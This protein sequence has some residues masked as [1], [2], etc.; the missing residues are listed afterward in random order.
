M[1]PKELRFEVEFLTPHAVAQQAAIPGSALKG[2]MLDAAR[3]LGPDTQW[4]LL[5]AVFGGHEHDIARAPANDYEGDSSITAGPTLSS[6]WSWSDI[7]WP[8]AKTPVRERRSRIR[9]DETTGT[10]LD[11]ALVAVNEFTASKGTFTIEQIGPIPGQ[12]NPLGLSLEDHVTVLE[13]A[14]RTMT[15]LGSDRRR[16]LGWVAVGLAG[17][18]PPPAELA[19]AF[20]TLL[21]RIGAVQ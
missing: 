19:E 1:N 2:M 12:F 16:G 15:A 18:A 10:A 6:P 17:D 11:G 4:K 5:R 7:V 14:A 3:D 9:I 20:Q 13:A 21:K 8:G